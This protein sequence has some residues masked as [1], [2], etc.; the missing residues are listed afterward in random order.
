MSIGRSERLCL[1]LIPC[2]FYWLEQV[3]M[4]VARGAANGFYQTIFVL[5]SELYPSTVRATAMG[6]GASCGWCRSRR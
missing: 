4:F 5:T 2:S 3:L 1:L 6:L